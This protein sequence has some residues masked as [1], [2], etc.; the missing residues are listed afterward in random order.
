MTDLEQKV[1]ELTEDFYL[2]G[3]AMFVE[4]IQGLPELADVSDEVLMSI[5]NSFAMGYSF[6]A[7]SVLQS[8]YAGETE[9][10]P[11]PIIQTIKS[12]IIIGDFS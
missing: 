2:A 5:K 1:A 4:N 7:M 3:E 9:K 10:E 6:G 8:G 11:E 12:N